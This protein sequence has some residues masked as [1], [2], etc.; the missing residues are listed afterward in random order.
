MPI[1]SLVSL[2]SLYSFLL[3]S[4]KEIVRF[5]DDQQVRRKRVGIAEEG[6]SVPSDRRKC[7]GFR[8]YGSNCYAQHR[9]TYST[10]PVVRQLRDNLRESIIFRSHLELRRSGCEYESNL[11]RGE[12]R[13]LLE[14]AN[15]AKYYSADFRRGVISSVV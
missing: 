7:R 10:R 6:I 12:V 4:H 2:V 14:P 13:S 11:C 9:Q 8:K 1:V 3:S 15:P 5:N